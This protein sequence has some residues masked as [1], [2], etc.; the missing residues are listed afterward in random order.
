MEFGR[1]RGV[2]RANTETSFF[3]GA[4]EEVGR[5]EVIK[6]GDSGAFA[7]E[8]PGGLDVVRQF[9]VLLPTAWTRGP[10]VFGV[11]VRRSL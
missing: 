7:S 1:D 4:I 11:S 9:S 8:R 10:C 3:S 5:S 2:E 6:A